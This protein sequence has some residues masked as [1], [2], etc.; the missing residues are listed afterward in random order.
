MKVNCNKNSD[1]VPD[2]PLRTK[3]HRHL[4]AELSPMSCKQGKTTARGGQDQANRPEPHPKDGHIRVPNEV[5]D[6]LAQLQASG[7]EWQ[8]IFATWRRTLGW[9]RPGEWRNDPYPISLGDLSRAT[10]LDRRH[11]ARAVKDL[12]E[13]NVLKRTPREWKHLLSFNLDHSIWVVSKRSLVTKQPLG[14][15]EIATDTGGEPDT[16]VVVKQPPPLDSKSHLLNKR[17]KVIKKHP[18]E[19]VQPPTSDEL[20]ILDIVRELKGWRYQEIDDFTWLRQFGIEFPDLGVT[21]VKACRDY[22]SGLSRLIHKGVWKNRLRNWMTKKR[23]FAKG[24]EEHARATANRPGA[25]FDIDII[26]SGE[27]ENE[28]RDTP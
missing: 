3:H 25:K 16:G 10:G 12:V 18:K 28:S 19:T 17:R 15:G 9:Q 5:V 24:G 26:E 11:I 13:R 20:K 23:D 8:I 14:S 21:D 6:R 1:F 2:S 22:F 4:A 27:E 7:A